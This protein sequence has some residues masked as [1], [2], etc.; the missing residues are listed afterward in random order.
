[1]YLLEP[2]YIF[3]EVKTRNKMFG[4]AKVARVLGAHFFFAMVVFI[5]KYQTAYA[6]K[7]NRNPV[8]HIALASA[9]TFKCH[10]CS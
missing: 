4:I 5:S 8:G 10:F 6:G 3:N 2:M 7:E 1:M 9:H